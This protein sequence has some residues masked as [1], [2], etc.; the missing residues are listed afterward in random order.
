M[1]SFVNN[2]INIFHLIYRIVEWVFFPFV[3]V[4]TRNDCAHSSDSRY[5][6]LKLA[7]YGASRLISE[8]KPA[9]FPWVF[10]EKW[11][12][13]VG[14][15]KLRSVLMPCVFYKDVNAN[16]AVQGRPPLGSSSPNCCGGRLWLWFLPTF[17]V[18]A[19]NRDRW[20]CSI[21]YLM[22]ISSITSIRDYLNLFRSKILCDTRT[23]SVKPVTID[24]CVGVHPK[25][26][27]IT[28]AWWRLARSSLFETLPPTFWKSFHTF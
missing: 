26:R 14:Q 22:I 23:R 1:N 9:G 5:Y 12:F 16:S 2:G 15:L 11:R 21:T 20:N 27:E 19:H 3:S 28:R 8:R 17:A 13:R 18:L 6:Q 24:A 4:H 7:N 10:F 25:A